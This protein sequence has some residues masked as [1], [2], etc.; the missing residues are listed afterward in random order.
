M[1]TLKACVALSRGRPSLPLTT[2]RIG[3]ATAEITSPQSPSS[4]TASK[5]GTRYL[6]SSWLSAHA[7]A[8]GP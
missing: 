6:H 7:A 8:V 4:P 2:V 3:S 5:A 1:P